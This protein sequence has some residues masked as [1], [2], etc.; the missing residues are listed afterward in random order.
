MG[1]SKLVKTAMFGNDANWGRI[2][3]AVG[4]A[5]VVFDANELHVSIG[6]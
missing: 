2:A 6:K 1:N 5:G 4:Y 3:A